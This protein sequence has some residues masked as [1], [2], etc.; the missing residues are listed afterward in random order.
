MFDVQE[1]TE[2]EK[3]I[4]LKIG[5]NVNVPTFHDPFFKMK[6]RKDIYDKYFSDEISYEEFNQVMKGLFYKGLITFVPASITILD[7]IS[8]T[9]GT[10]VRFERS[11]KLEEEWKSNGIVRLTKGNERT[12]PGEDVYNFLIQE[13]LNEK[14]KE[15]NE[16]LEENQRVVKRIESFEKN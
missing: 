9:E 1:L 12:V 7:N 5:D 10:K 3:K 15:I 2:I 11:Y 6:I 13:N 4:I 14:Y 16:K 8:G